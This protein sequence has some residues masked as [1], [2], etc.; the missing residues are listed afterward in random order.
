M[1]T[2]KTMTILALSAL[3]ILASVGCAGNPNRPKTVAV[4]S[5]GKVFAAPAPIEPSAAERH[6][7]DFA[8]AKTLDGQL[9]AA[10][11]ASRDPRLDIADRV[12]WAEKAVRLALRHPTFDGGDAFANYAAFADAARAANIP[13]NPIFL[14]LAA[15]HH[16]LTR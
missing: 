10:K 8:A 7:A 11:A 4:D 3:T 1:N 15:A 9:A 14:N 12:A 5:A 6:A 13:L 2:K 16:A